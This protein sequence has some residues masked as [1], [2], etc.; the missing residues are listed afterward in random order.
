MLKEYERYLDRIDT[1]D[2]D[3]PNNNRMIEKVKM[4]LSRIEMKIDRLLIKKDMEFEKYDEYFNRITDI[5]YVI[6]DLS[7]PCYK[8]NEYLKEYYFAKNKS[9]P[10]LAKKLWQCHYMLIHSDYTQLKNKC[11]H[12]YYKLDNKFKLANDSDLIDSNE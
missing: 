4:A 7:L 1:I 10:V 8:H 3:L 12:L 9:H 6:A 11:Y 5:L 2:L